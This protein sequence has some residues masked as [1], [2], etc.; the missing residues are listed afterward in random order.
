M[1]TIFTYIMHDGQSYKIGKSRDPKLRLN[2]LKTG[3][4]HLKLYA[5]FYG[6]IEKLCHE[7]FFKHKIRNEW[8]DFSRK[9]MFNVY[10]F[11]CNNSNG[12]CLEDVYLNL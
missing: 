5:Y 4:P 10:N 3:N 9:D 12:P 1:E 6:D 11:M 8:F 7:K 2:S